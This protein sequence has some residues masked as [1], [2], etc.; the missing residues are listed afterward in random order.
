MTLS[1]ARHFILTNSHDIVGR[2]SG[3]WDEKRLKKWNEAHVIV[4][5][6]M[7]LQ[8]RLTIRE[9]KDRKH[10]IRTRM[11]CVKETTAEGSTSSSQDSSQTQTG[12]LPPISPR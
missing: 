8:E 9:D 4:H 6:E 10:E 7:T 5:D 3:Q 1:E 11:S 12:N 2:R